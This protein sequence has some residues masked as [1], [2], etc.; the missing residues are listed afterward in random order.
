[1]KNWPML[2]AC[3]ES[4]ELI[5]HKWNQ[6]GPVV[7]PYV[8]RDSSPRPESQGNEDD[9]YSTLHPGHRNKVV[10]SVLT[11]ARRMG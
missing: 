1:M 11:R 2:K 5:T 4:L 7:P 10:G 6:D 3:E 8:A 9:R